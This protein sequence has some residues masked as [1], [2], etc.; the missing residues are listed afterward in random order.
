MII[1]KLAPSVDSP[2]SKAERY[3]SVLFAV[4]G[5]SLSKREIQLISYMAVEGSISYAPV[6]DGF[7]EKYGSSP[8]TINNMVSRLRK[9]GVLVKDRGRVKVLPRIVL[10]FKRNIAL[11]IKFVNG[12]DKEG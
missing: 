6:R 4:N 8:A 12:V 2:L 5:I 10:D 3:Y 7:C 11:E 9:L 1:Q